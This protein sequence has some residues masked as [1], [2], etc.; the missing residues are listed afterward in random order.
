MKP[1]PF[2]KPDSSDNDENDADPNAEAKKPSPFLEPDST[3]DDES[4]ADP[5]ADSANSGD[6]DAGSVVKWSMITVTAVAVVAILIIIV[7]VAYIFT[8]KMNA[9]G[10]QQYVRCR[11][12]RGVGI[13]E[14][15]VE[16]PVG[17]RQFYHTM[18]NNAVETKA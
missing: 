18:L 3:D 1:S 8:R 11:I 17:I 10:E 4:D 6:A 9:N 14:G 12:P 13:R 2:A 16:S 5:D 15:G 7:L